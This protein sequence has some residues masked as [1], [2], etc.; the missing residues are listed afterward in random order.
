MGKSPLGLN[1]ESLLKIYGVRGRAY[2]S[3]YRIQ[4]YDHY[5]I[6]EEFFSSLVDKHNLI[7]PHRVSDVLSFY[8]LRYSLFA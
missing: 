7:D 6:N 2:N 3:S 5:T 8:M 1:E 4:I